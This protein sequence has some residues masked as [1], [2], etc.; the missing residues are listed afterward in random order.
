MMHLLVAKDE[1]LL[2]LTALNFEHTRLFGKIPW[3]KSTNCE[4]RRKLTARYHHLFLFVLIIVP[5]VQN[6]FLYLAASFIHHA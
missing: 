3:L 6:E 2:V 4:D 1:I 5:E